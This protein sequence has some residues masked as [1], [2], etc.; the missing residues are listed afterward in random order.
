MTFP[1]I[2][3]FAG[4]HVHAHLVFEMLGYAVGFQT[5]RLLRR[6]SPAA[7]RLP[8]E[9]TAWLI[10]YAILRG[11]WLQSARV[12]RILAQLPE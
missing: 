1:V 12:D 10:A 3:N 9:I 4:Y 8:I 5:Y 11:R 2:Y 7:D 6:K